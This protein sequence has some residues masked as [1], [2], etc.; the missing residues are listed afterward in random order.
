MRQ[1]VRL[2]LEV[3]KTEFRSQIF[4]TPLENRKKKLLTEVR[5]SCTTNET[6]TRE[7]TIEGKLMTVTTEE[8]ETAVKK[9]GLVKQLDREIFRQNC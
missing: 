8:V 9:L 4:K 2:G 3:T 7:T 5:I 6:I 1:F